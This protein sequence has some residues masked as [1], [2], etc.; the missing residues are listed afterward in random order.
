M[1]FAEV[2]R[3]LIEKITAIGHARSALLSRTSAGRTRQ[4]IA[5]RR[6][7]SNRPPTCAIVTGDAPRPR[8]AGRYDSRRKARP[9]AS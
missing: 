1:D 3:F 8:G 5:T 2:N 9:L 6:R 4:R 7:L